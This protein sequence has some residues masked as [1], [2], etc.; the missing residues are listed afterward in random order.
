MS[1]TDDSSKTEK[2]TPKKL[3]DARKEGNVGKS[4]D[5]TTVIALIVFITLLILLK[6]LFVKDISS[7]YYLA[8]QTILAG[9]FEQQNLYAVI[10]QM[11]K[12]TLTLI[13]IFIFCGAFAAVVSVIVQSGG[14]TISDKV[15]K[16]D[17]QKLDIVTN[18]KE[19]FSKKNFLKVILNCFKFAI[20]AGIATYYI[21]KHLSQLLL[22]S[23]ITISQIVSLV[24]T[25]VGKSVIALLGVFFIF[26]CIDL[27]LEKKSVYSKLMMSKEEIKKEN[28]DMEGD[29]E[30]KSRRKE[31][32]QELLNDDIGSENAESMFVVANPTHIAILV[33]YVPLRVRLPIILLKVK[34]AEATTVFQIAR[35]RKIPIFREKWLARQLYELAI[36]NKP[37]PATLARDLATLIVK[38][39]DSLPKIA[40]DMKTM[41]NL[42][43]H[44]TDSQIKV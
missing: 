1:S 10:F 4:K 41:A 9:Q 15:F 3:R 16:F 29:P 35:R 17:L 33:I 26:A 25:I 8:F 32:H 39:L 20:L 37:V 31:L 14:F 42:K 40:E 5:L 21:Y 6:F 24:A 30:I 18:T 11:L 44:T 43:K 13:V 23:N 22:M 12:N 34:D 38:N 27:F 28:K 19:L 2:P 7:G 36:I